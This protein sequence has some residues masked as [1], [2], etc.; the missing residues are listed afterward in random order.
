MFCS[1]CLTRLDKVNKAYIRCVHSADSLNKINRVKSIILQN[2]KK[3]NDEKVVTDGDYVC[4]KCISFAENHSRFADN[5]QI[6]QP[7]ETDSDFYS[8]TLQTIKTSEIVNENC[9]NNLKESDT[10]L[11]VKNDQRPIQ[12]NKVDVELFRTFSGHKKCIICRRDTDS[13]KLRLIPSK[14]I[15]KVFLE[16]DIFIPFGSR[17][18]SFHLNEYLQLNDDSIKSL[19]IVSN[20]AKIT[21]KNVIF[22]FEALKESVKSSNLFAKFGDL[23]MLEDEDCYTNTGFRKDEFLYIF[24]SLT[25]L[26]NSTH[27]SKSQ[28]LAIYLYW[29]KTG[30]NQENIASIFG[31]DQRDVSRYCSQIRDSLME[32]FVKEHLGAKR[33]DRK[34][35][36]QHNSVI[37]KE[38][39]ISDENQFAIIA[40]GTYC[41]CQKSSDNAF[42]RRTYSSQKKRHLVKPFVIC[43][44]DGQII[45]V[46]G[47]FGANEND[48]SIFTN[49]LK[50]SDDLRELLQPDDVVLLDRGFR[51]CINELKVKYKLRPFYPSCNL[52]YKQINSKILL[53]N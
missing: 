43:A 23:E 48:A 11:L 13:R 33:I 25:S 52:F 38:L 37:V 3:Q 24:N 29:L 42:Q 34:A 53:I 10:S 4:G 1:C 50:E 21:S 15:V 7:D 16:C 39:F 45:D 27:R 20:S 49:I 6:A 18:C 41:Y 32:G 40:D 14:S 28:A 30:L 5:V 51:D 46:Y 8:A 35:W 19:I 47:L 44:T 36:I 2:N 31:I 26:K 17:C 9:T 22:M 12:M